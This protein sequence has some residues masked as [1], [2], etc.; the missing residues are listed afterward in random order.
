MSQLRDKYNLIIYNICMYEQ[1]LT[2][3]GLTKEQAVIYQALLKGGILPARK[4]SLLTNIKRGLVYK[5]LELMINMGIIEERN[6]LG[7]I[8]MFLCGHPTKILEIVEK[9]Q[10]EA[11]SAKNSVENILGSMI[12]EY[13]FFSGKPYV[14]FYEGVSGLKKL[15]DDIIYQGKDIKLIR[16]PMD[17]DTPE[18]TDLVKD[19]I[20]RQVK[21]GIRIKALTPTKSQPL[22]YAARFDKE[23]NMERCWVPRDMFNMPAQ[24]IIYGDKVGI[25]SYKDGMFTTI[26]EN[27]S[28]KETFETMFEYMW[29]MSEKQS[30][31]LIEK[32]RITD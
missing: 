12:S 21:R 4:I 16:S 32:T 19:Q 2:Q 5:N 30:R 22:S 27:P 25:T 3:A 26:I 6:N 1:F 14:R 31:E 10:K 20:Q 18:L 24:I 29:K 13:N 11:E 28:I 7:K 8:A 23:R 15:Y 17:D 9:K